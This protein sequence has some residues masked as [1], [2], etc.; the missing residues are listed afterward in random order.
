[1]DNV[2]LQSCGKKMTRLPKKNSFGEPKG[3][4]ETDRERERDIEDDTSRF[5]FLFFS[6][7][8]VFFSSLKRYGDH[9]QGAGSYHRC[10]GRVHRAHLSSPP[11]AAS[12]RAGYNLESS[13]SC[14]GRK[15]KSCHRL[16][17]FFSNCSPVRN[18]R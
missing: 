5:F 18:A 11:A 9:C 4:E 2:Y 3:S 16:F 13:R 1:M 7:V 8:F 15:K 10:N 17:R 12:R 14:D 6:L